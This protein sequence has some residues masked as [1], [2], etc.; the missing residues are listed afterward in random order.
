MKCQDWED[1]V[2]AYLDNE[3]DAVSAIRF[4]AHLDECMACQEALGS[5]E[6]CRVCSAAGGCGSSLRPNCDSTW[7]A[8]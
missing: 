6:D 3:L 1:F 4:Q 7:S 2:D 8:C 5:R